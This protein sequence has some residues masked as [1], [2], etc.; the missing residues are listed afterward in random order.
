MLLYII[1]ES[2]I[3]NGKENPSIK[4]CSLILRSGS[5]KVRLRQST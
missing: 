1:V 3:K 5:H 4:S 2:F